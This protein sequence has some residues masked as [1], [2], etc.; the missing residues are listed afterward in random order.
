M[1]RA[2]AQLTISAGHGL[3][4]T[5]TIWSAGPDAGTY[6]AHLDKE[7]VLIKV[8]QLQHEARPTVTVE[9]HEA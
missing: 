8:R 1:I 7:V 4:R 9:E 5:V 2:G 3:G 6:W